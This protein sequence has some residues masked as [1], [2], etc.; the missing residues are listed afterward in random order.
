MCENIRVH[1]KHY[2][3]SDK[4]ALYKLNHFC[5]NVKYFQ[6]LYLEA[7][8]PA[9]IDLK[10]IYMTNYES[11]TRAVS[12]RGAGGFLGAVL[13]AVIVDKYEKKLDLC[14]ALGTILSGVSVMLVPMLPS[15]DYVWLLYFVIGCSSCMVNMGKL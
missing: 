14:M 15:I 8:G 1:L 10:L 7:L 5:L 4:F 9:M 2:T 6:G 12:G 3:I 11:I 13:G